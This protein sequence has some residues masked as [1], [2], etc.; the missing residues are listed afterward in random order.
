MKAIALLLTAATL[1]AAAPEVSREQARSFQRKLSQIVQHAETGSDKARETTVTEGE[2]NSYLRF[3]AGDR[4]PTGV[5]EPSI[6]VH[7]QGRLSGRAIVDLDAIRRKRSSGGWFD[8]TSYLTGRLPVTADGVLQTHE[9]RGKFLLQNATVGGVP[10][11]KPFLQEIVSFYSRTP[12][13]PN[14]IDIDAPF[15]L[16]AAIQRIDVHAGRATIIQ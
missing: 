6:G 11:P 10:I 16:P 2:V 12:E 3:S 4:I 14:G 1:A 9:G 13:F 8:P 5:T 15:E 7:G